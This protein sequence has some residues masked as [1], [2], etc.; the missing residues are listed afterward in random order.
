MCEAALL[1]RAVGVL[2]K[3]S[4]STAVLIRRRQCG[5]RSVGPIRRASL[6]Q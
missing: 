2:L 1:E 3:S 6:L 4:G 5:A